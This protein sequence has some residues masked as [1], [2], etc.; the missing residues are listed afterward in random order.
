MIGDCATCG[1]F[2]GA[3]G[4]VSGVVSGQCGGVVENHVFKS[5]S[6]AEFVPL[7][8]DKPDESAKVLQA[9][10][11][12]ADALAPLAQEDRVRVVRAAVILA[13]IELR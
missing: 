1:H 11:L 2:K 4:V 6:C 7:A 9:F 8:A 12:V 13:G 3:H 10:N 5:C